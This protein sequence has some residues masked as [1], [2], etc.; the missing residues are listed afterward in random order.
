MVASYPTR[1]LVV[2]PFAIMP[3][4][5]RVIGAILIEPPRIQRSP[6]LMVVIEPAGVVL[7]PPIGIAPLVLIV[8]AAPLRLGR[9]G[10]PVFIVKGLPGVRMVGHVI[11]QFRILRAPLGVVE[12]S[13]IP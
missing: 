4:I 6:V 3:L 10:R 8:I 5:L 9:S 13:G 11:F 7:M 1:I 2:P 12:Q